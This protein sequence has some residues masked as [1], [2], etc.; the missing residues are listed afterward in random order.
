MKYDIILWPRTCAVF[1]MH[2]HINA[3]K[4]CCERTRTARRRA[5]CGR[6]RLRHA[7]AILLRQA[8]GIAPAWYRRK[9]TNVTDVVRS[10]RRTT[11]NQPPGCSRGTVVHFAS[12]VFSFLIRRFCRRL[13]ARLTFSQL[14]FQIFLDILLFLL[15]FS[16]KFLLSYFFYFYFFL[17]LV[18][19]ITYSY[20]IC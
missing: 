12:I 20:I 14:P 8:N 9:P 5:L 7:A 1:R 16:L 13:H 18:Q 2:Y 10:F 3:M 19:C 11:T 15:S 17:L 6:R 4:R